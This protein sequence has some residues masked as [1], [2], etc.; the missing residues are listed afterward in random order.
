MKIIHCLN[1]RYLG[2]KKPFRRYEAES[3]QG[4]L[5]NDTTVITFCEVDKKSICEEVIIN[6]CLRLNVDN[7][8]KVFLHQIQSESPFYAQILWDVS[9][10]LN[11]NGILYVEES[12]SKDIL[13]DNHYYRDSF[14]FIEKIDN[15]ILKFIKIKALAIENDKGLDEWSFGIP[16]GNDD[17]TFLNRCIERIL[18]LDIPKKEI[19]LCG[20]PH[21]DFKYSDN[22]TIIEDPSEQGKIHITKKKNLLAKNAKY[23]NICI[24]H[25]RILLPLDFYKS[26]KKFGDNYPITGFQ[27]FYF[28]DKNNFIPRRYSDYNTISQD[29]TQELS[30]D[31]ITVKDTSLISKMFYCYQHPARSDFG[32]DYLT[33]SLYLTKKSLWNLYPQNEKLYWN[34]YEDVEFGVRCSTY[35]IPTRINPWTITQSMNSRSII[36][37]YGYLASK[38]YNGKVSMVRSLLEMIPFVG[39]KPLFRIYEEE[40]RQKLYLFGRKYGANKDTL[41]R[42]SSSSM[43]GITRFL[44]IRKVINEITVKL[45]N[46]EV[47]LK[48]FSKYVLCESMAPN[49][50][51][52]VLRVMY[53]SASPKTKKNALI[54]SFILNN[55]LHHS[56]SSS[57]FFR[58]IDDWFIKKNIKSTLG[59]IVSAFYLKY[60]YRGVYIPYSWKELVIKLKE[61]TPWM[62]RLL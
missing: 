18:C 45:S 55:Q 61:T 3:Y 24:F 27:S 35:G 6:G 12:M 29:L 14:Q 57:P 52:Y 34:D 10:N 28:I 7:I 58:N 11:L 33:G 47:F 50:Y 30:I 38:Y 46:T 31:N 8:E 4:L 21:E 41:L 26:V 2:L 20:Q 19:I 25:D 53:S 16:T 44:I 40:A 39:R 60:L 37:Y 48:D 54:S 22:V 59:I 1:D 17:P 56:F 13:L 43:Q 15:K 62:D 42:I 23:K 51:K 9:H 36:H 49:E 5:D 32:H